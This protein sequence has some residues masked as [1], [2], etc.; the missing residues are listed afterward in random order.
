MAS[1]QDPKTVMVIKGNKPLG[2]RYHRKHQTII[3]ASDTA[4]LDVVT[5]GDNCWQPIPTIPMNLMTFN[6][7]DLMSFTSEPFKLAGRTGFQRFTKFNC[8]EE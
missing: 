4:Y 1:R 7:D 5:M 3:Y 8:E 2:L 6:C